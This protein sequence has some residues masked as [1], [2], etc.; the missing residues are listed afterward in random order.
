MLLL[1]A[2]LPFVT[3][4]LRV[5]GNT[6]VERRALARRREF[7]TAVASLVTQA[8]DEGDLRPDVDPAVISRL[9]YG[10]INSVVEWYRPRGGRPGGA[11]GQHRRGGVRRAPA[12]A[13]RP[14]SPRFRFLG[15][16]FLGFRFLG[17]RFLEVGM[18][19]ELVLL[20]TAGAP[21]PMAGRGGISSAVIADGRVFVVDCGRGSSS[22]FVEA[23]LDFT[24]LEAV[25]LTHL[26]V[27][28]IGDLP[29]MIL[30][31][32]GVRGALPP[33]RV[34]GPS[35]QAA[36]PEGNAVFHRVT[37]IHP[38]LPAPARRI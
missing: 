17:F 28:H 27:D 9:L 22:A 16:R 32:W 5:R 20:G 33:L 23:G 14:D 19:T 1:V 10:M 29:G 31:P 6:K 30:Y 3:L 18:A 13:L 25:F 7:D 12:Q 34:Y 4:L 11:G 2:E 8:R 36:L 37:T 15:F 38:E 24:R 35:P 26:H 21:L